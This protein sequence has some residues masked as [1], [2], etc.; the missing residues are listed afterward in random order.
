M[1]FTHLL[2]FTPVALAIVVLPACD[3]KKPSATTSIDGA[4]AAPAPVS[5]A[6]SAPIPATV[7]DPSADLVTAVKNATH[8]SRDTL[9]A[10][11][12]TFDQRVETDLAALKTAGTDVDVDAEKKVSESKANVLKILAE[13]ADA[14]AETWPTAQSNAL[15]ALQEFRTAWARAK[16]GRSTT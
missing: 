9:R 16:S 12:E 10:A 1:N 6:Q 5:V 4:P 7:I 8:A 15:A 13:L 3:A 14:P 2:R 11:R